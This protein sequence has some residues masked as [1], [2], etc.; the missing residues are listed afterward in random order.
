MDSDSRPRPRNRARAR[1]IRTGAA[2]SSPPAPA[3]PASTRRLR[4]S[5]R[6]TGPE[7]PADR[8]AASP[9]ACLGGAARPAR[10]RGRR[11]RKPAAPRA[12]SRCRAWGSER[13][14]AR[15]GRRG[16]RPRRIGCVAVDRNGRAAHAEATAQRR[17]V[18]DTS[19][20]H[21]RRAVEER[22]PRR[23]RS[24]VAP[25]RPAGSTAWCFRP[26]ASARDGRRAAKARS[27]R[28]GHAGED[29]AP[30]DRARKRG[31]AGA[32]GG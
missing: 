13:N 32:R 4:S 31:W 16:S 24:G 22:E 30:R 7:A 17:D 15:R 18:A 28:D 3:L 14:R 25:C 2:G 20:D 12:N 9:P 6:R 19:A 21:E 23:G 1:A 27:E 10:R 26:R 5:G 29:R 11:R 8:T